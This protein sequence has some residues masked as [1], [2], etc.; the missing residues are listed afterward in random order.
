MPSRKIHEIRRENMRD[1]V[2]KH[3]DGGTTAVA[4]RL[5]YRNAS[6]LSQQIGPNPTREITEKSAR[7]YE[8]ELGLPKG[9]LDVD[10]NTPAVDTT[11]VLGITADLVADVVRLVGSVLQAEALVVQPKQF[12]D[13]TA[14]ALTDAVEHGNKPRESY[15][16][17]VAQLLK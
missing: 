10:R 1:V 11:P 3:P 16:K 13:I 15:V 5:G 7:R 9:F 8:E 6:F 2:D 14:L 4:K 12:G 17:Q